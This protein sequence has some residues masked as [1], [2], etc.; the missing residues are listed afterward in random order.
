MF[1]LLPDFK[2]FWLVFHLLLWVERILKLERVLFNFD[3]NLVE[4][5]LPPVDAFSLL[6]FK[7][8][9]VVEL[10]ELLEEFDYNV[11]DN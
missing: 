8:T 11:Q 2:E 10:L 6:L 7:L 5:V 9:L 3:I 1:V 4:I